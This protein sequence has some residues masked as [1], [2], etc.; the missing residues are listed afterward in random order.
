MSTSRYT[1]PIP[2]ETL[3]LETRQQL[4]ELA[5]VYSMGTLDDRNGGYYLLD[6]EGV[7]LAVAADGLCEEL[8][9]S[10]ASAKGVHEQSPYSELGLHVQNHFDKQ[11]CAYGEGYTGTVRLRAAMAGHLNRRFWPW[12]GIDGVEVTFAAGVTNLNEVCAL[13]L[14]DADQGD[15]IMLGRP[16][17]G[18]FS[19]ELAM[20]TGIN[21][22]YVSAGDTE[23]FSPACVTALES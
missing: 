4:R 1:V 2:S 9:A 23:Q 8:D 21:L 20:R 18:A 3:I 14:C 15:G 13:S 16:V 10:M 12:T 11:C 19:G 5:V 6:A 7:V 17:Y 22:E